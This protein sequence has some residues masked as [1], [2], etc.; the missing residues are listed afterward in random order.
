MWHIYKSYRNPEKGG[1]RS[2]IYENFFPYMQLTGYATHWT[3]RRVFSAS[4]WGIA[5]GKRFLGQPFKN[6]LRVNR[7]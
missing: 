3:S 5:S 7:Y 6:H 2:N 4:M 1:G